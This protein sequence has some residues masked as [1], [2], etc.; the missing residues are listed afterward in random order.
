[1]EGI[2]K[3]IFNV[4]NFFIYHLLSIK[5]TIFDEIIKNRFVLIIFFIFEY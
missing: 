4:V 1:M 2:W 3:N 5:L